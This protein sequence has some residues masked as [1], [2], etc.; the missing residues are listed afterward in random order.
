[1]S[2]IQNKKVNLAATEY[3]AI[4]TPTSVR[5][6]SHSIRSNGAQR[7]KKEASLMG[8]F[9]LAPLGACCPKAGIQPPSA[10]QQAASAPLRIGL[11]F[12]MDFIFC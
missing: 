9:V 11:L 12:M 6:V 7:V 1:L 3:A 10:K 4:C 2:H 5:S 8:A